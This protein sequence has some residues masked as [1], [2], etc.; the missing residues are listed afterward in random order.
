MT[1]FQLADDFLRI[2]G[3]GLFGL[4]GVLWWEQ[5]SFERQVREFQE[6]SDAQAAKNDGELE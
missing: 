6:W 3:L 4:I 2:C 1:L 5:R